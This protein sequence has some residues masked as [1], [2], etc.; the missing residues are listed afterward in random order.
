MTWCSF[1]DALSVSIHGRK[2]LK[3]KAECKNMN[4][5][6]KPYPINYRIFN[7]CDI[8]VLRNS[9]YCKPN[10]H[11]LLII[12]FNTRASKI[13]YIQMIYFQI[14]KVY[15]IAMHSN[16]ELVRKTKVVYL[17]S[18][19]DMRNCKPGLWGWGFVQ[20]GLLGNTF[21]QDDTTSSLRSLSKEFHRHTCASV[22]PH[23]RSFCVRVEGTA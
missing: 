22:N 7:Y 6:K 8:T 9:C 5:K 21:L 14:F 10:V 18:F 15:C 13:Q 4:L 3:L 20:E 2:L 17:L 19:N 1:F 16:W 23:D 11:F 12:L